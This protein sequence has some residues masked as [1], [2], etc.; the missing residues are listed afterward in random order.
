MSEAA[1]MP[2]FPV[3]FWESVDIMC[4]HYDVDDMQRMVMP[5]PRTLL[6]KKLD[7]F[8]ATVRQKSQWW[9]KAHKH[10]VVERW[11]SEAAQQDVD[12]STFE[13]G[14]QVRCTP[15][16]GSG[17]SALHSTHRLL[18]ALVK[19]KTCTYDSSPVALVVTILYL[20]M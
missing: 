17:T 7:L 2:R 6:E 10:D 4:A 1:S 13:F 20:H 5:E 9:V 16:M 11:R 15:N 19:C 14:L 3:P 12:D 18:K 8:T